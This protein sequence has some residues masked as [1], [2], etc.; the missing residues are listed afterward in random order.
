MSTFLLERADIFIFALDMGNM[1]S[2]LLQD[3]GR[4]IKNLS[5]LYLKMI[6]ERGA[7]LKGWLS[8][9]IQELTGLIIRIEEFVILR[10][11]YDRISN[12]ITSKREQIGTMSR[13]LSLLESSK[14]AGSL[15]KDDKEITNELNTLA[16][17][18]GLTLSDVE[19][20]M[21]KYI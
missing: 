7:Q 18:L 19:N 17:S 16:S 5:S 8:K 6:K 14:Y 1:R 13:V 4:L 20:Q 2:H 21:P 9:S 12:D 15:T 11:N 10:G 3:Q